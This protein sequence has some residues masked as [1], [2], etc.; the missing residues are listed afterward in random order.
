MCKGALLP[1]AHLLRAYPKHPAS[2]TPEGKNSREVHKLYYLCNQHIQAVMA[3]DDYD[4]DM[5]LAIV[6]EP[7]SDE[8][9]KLKL[10]EFGNDSQ[11][12]PSHSE[13]LKFLNL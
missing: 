5:F 12:T 9:T 3:S 13:L 6:M 8:V 10:M 1:K 2:S 11:S 7:N 4:I